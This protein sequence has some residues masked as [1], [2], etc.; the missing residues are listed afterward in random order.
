MS[1][2]RVDPTQAGAEERV[3]LAISATL[4]VAAVLALVGVVVPG[5]WGTGLATA[6]IAIV[7]AIPIVR[8]GWLV[9]RWAG[10][11]DTKYA[12]AAVVLLALVAVGP[13]IA[14]LQH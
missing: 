7:T 1:D 5:D 11:R 6:A 13:V 4:L 12:W 2:H 3:G 9:K 10:Q 14:L 8:V